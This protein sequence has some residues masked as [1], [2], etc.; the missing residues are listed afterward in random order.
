M[1]KILF[2]F[3][4]LNLF[5]HVLFSQAII[6]LSRTDSAA[7]KENDV[8]YEEYINKGDKKEA[9]R[10][11]DLNAVIY[12][13]H[14]YY[15]QAVDYYTK[16]LR[17]NEQLGNQNGIAGI[18]SNLALIYADNGDYQKAYDFFEKTLAVRKSKNESIGIISALIN[19]SVVLNKMSRFDEAVKK[20]E[21]ALTFAREIND[22]AQMRSVFG[23]L[24]E[25]YQKAG[26]NTKAMYYYEFYKTFNDYVTD[27]V[28]AKTQHQLNEEILQKQVLE[29]ENENKQLELEKQGWVIIQQSEEIGIITEE[30]QKLVD[31]LTKQ[32]MAL[33]I[34]TQRSKIQE[35]ENFTLTQEK[36]LQ[37]TV[38]II[39]SI[40]LLIVIGLLFWLFII[41]R[42]KNRLNVEL[43]HKNSIVNQ[44][45]EE[46]STQNQ[47][48]LTINEVVTDKNNQI[49]SSITYAQKI[50][51][52]ILSGSDK[53]VDL[54]ADSFLVYYP[55][56]IVSGD[57]YFFKKVDNQKILVV[58][59]C[60]GH[61]VPGAF[62]TV[63]GSN[64]L[65]SIIF[66]K[67]I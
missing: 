37:K 9:C 10:R 26:N 47:Q 23:M 18:N 25:T 3:I 30:Q 51:Y 65:N 34:V 36:K 64:I 58:G 40:V 38:I 12:W 50:Q 31:S 28:V 2:L 39:I 41:Y 17:L 66:D 16:S 62:L 21:E 15:N 49:T 43:I 24:S 35:L 53:L 8:I 59:D 27:K 20:L 63:L 7:I 42:Q 45:K 54:V 32:E 60:T 5:S 19:E 6:P 55:R 52:A 29:L 22:E 46:I 4:T 57:F 1:K 56:D 33:E 11:L 13:K 61:G 67:H 48:L 14:N 44:Q